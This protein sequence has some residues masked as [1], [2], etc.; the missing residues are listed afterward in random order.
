MKTRIVDELTI[1]PFV[2]PE[3][4][5]EW[6][7]SLED[8]LERF[9]QEQIV[10]QLTTDSWRAEGSF[11]TRFDDPRFYGP[12]SVVK[13][14]YQL[15]LRFVSAEGTESIVLELDYDPESGDL[16]PLRKPLN[17][18]TIPMQQERERKSKAV[19]EA[20]ERRLR[21]EEEIDCPFC[22]GRLT[23]WIQDFAPTVKQV[24]CPTKG[25]FWVHFS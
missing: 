2:T 1:G 13:H 15:D 8:D 10:P 19:S 4:K 9:I 23:F 25:C 6:E 16:K 14:R 22:G 24:V 18:Y 3:R 5:R 11:G 21:G 7:R 17:V 20:I 12:H